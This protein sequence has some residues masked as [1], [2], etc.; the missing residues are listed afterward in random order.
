MATPARKRA[1][2]S[3]NAEAIWTAHAGKGYVSLAKL[4]A[5]LGTTDPLSLERAWNELRDARLAWGDPARGERS[6]V[7]KRPGDR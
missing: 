5:S 6:K 7:L 1:K 3:Q 4:T 2:L